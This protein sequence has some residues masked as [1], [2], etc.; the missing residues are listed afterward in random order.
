LLGVGVGR[1][2]ALGGLLSSRGLLRHAR[3]GFGAMRA[4][5]GR[6]RRFPLLAT[7]SALLTTAG[8]EAPLLI[9]SAFYGDVRAG[10]LGLTIRVFSGPTLVIGQAIDQVF[11]GE[12]SAAIRDPQG[13]LRRLMRATVGRLVLLGAAPAIILGLFGPWIF[14]VIFGSGWTEAGVYAQLLAVPY[15]LQFAVNPVSGVLLYLERQGQMLAWSGVRLVLTAGGPVVC[16]LVGLPITGAIA[17]LSIG[18]V[19]S[20]AVLYFLCARAVGVA[21]DEYRRRRP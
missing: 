20:Y 13:N 14:G 12:S 19:L 3:P 18:H 4:A 8:L 6:F 16:A 1:L 11:S 21:D 7:P 17:A 5:L 15:L 2:C 9:I 10:L